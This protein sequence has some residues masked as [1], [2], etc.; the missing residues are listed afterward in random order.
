MTGSTFWTVAAALN[1]YWYRDEDRANAIS[2]NPEHACANAIAW[3]REIAKLFDHVTVVRATRLKGKNYRNVGQACDRP[4]LREDMRDIFQWV[5]SGSQPQCSPFAAVSRLGSD[6]LEIL[7]RHL[8]QVK[9]LEVKTLWPAHYRRPTGATDNCRDRSRLVEAMLS[10]PDT[11]S[12]LS[13]GDMAEKIGT[14]TSSP[15][16]RREWFGKPEFDYWVIETAIPSMAKAYRYVDPNPDQIFAFLLIQIWI[17]LIPER[18]S[19]IKFLQQHRPYE[20]NLKA[21][22]AL[23]LTLRVPPAWFERYNGLGELKSGHDALLLRAGISIR[24]RKQGHTLSWT[25]K[26]GANESWAATRRKNARAMLALIRAA[27]F[28]L[29]NRKTGEEPAQDDIRHHIE[30]PDEYDFAPPYGPA[31]F[32]QMQH[33]LD[34]LSASLDYA[35]V[36]DI[37]DETGER[38]PLAEPSPEAEKNEE[39][40]RD[41]VAKGYDLLHAY[42]TA[43]H[44]GRKKGKKNLHN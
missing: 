3:P 2:H 4:S 16:F 27:G 41:R 8:P 25:V 44:R 10:T 34:H 31:V 15:K 18:L 35:V 1:W 43:E 11:Q 29:R 24:H 13:R 19:D 28:K 23:S 36:P 42:A 40:L 14:S 6:P 22:S 30:F 33:Q 5:S 17:L 21:G 9:K 39:A 20:G 7:V 12:L 38:L 32:Q 26:N 37:D